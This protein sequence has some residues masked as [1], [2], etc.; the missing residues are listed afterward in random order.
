MKALENRTIDNKVEMDVLDALDEI[1]AINQRHERIDT[2]QLLA[3]L[4]GKT[5]SLNTTST[6]SSLNAEDEELLRQFKAKKY[7]QVVANEST[8]PTEASIIDESSLSTLEVKK[9]PQQ[10]LA[11]QLKK[12]KIDSSSNN[13]HI[14]TVILKKKR[15]IEAVS[16]TS[17]EKSPPPIAVKPL[18][19]EKKTVALESLSTGLGVAYDSD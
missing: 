2:N 13:S 11:E 3:S 10:M 6:S 7:G 12:Q 4:N 15:K 17:S 9:N 19:P 8:A 18:E 14:P 5:K 1:K 16:V